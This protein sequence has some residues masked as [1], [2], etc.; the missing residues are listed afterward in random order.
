MGNRF[1]YTDHPLIIVVEGDMYYK[2]DGI[3]NPVKAAEFFTGGYKK[4]N[5]IKVPCQCCV[6]EY[7]MKLYNCCIDK[8]DQLG[9]VNVPRCAKIALI[10]AL[11]V[12]PLL[13]LIC[14]CCCRK[15]EYAKVEREKTKSD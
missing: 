8:L 13:L 15:T 11:W 9:M 2:Y 7:I 3:F 1:N 14:C 6:C 12:L 5:G 10:T 4:T